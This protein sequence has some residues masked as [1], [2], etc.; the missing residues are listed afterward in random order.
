MRAQSPRASGEPDAE[1]PSAPSTVPVELLGR[2]VMTRLHSM[3]VEL[4]SAGTEPY[5]V[6]LSAEDEH[7]LRHSALYAFGQPG[8]DA[9]GAP[10]GEW[11][12]FLLRWFERTVSLTVSFDAR[13]TSVV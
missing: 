7:R 5:L 9:A 1:P 2:R 10:D 11:R 8:A 3:V 12:T 6:H 4:R 13:E